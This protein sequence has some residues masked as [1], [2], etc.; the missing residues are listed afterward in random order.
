MPSTS[1]A[2]RSILPPLVLLATVLL[3]LFG[4][5]PGAGRWVRVLTDSAHAPASAVIAA[6]FFSWR[7]AAATPR[8]LMHH[9]IVSLALTVTLGVLIEIMQYFIG[10]DAELDDVIMDALGALA[11]TSIC[12]LA[13]A[14]RGPKQTQ[15]WLSSAALTIALLTTFVVAWPVLVMAKAYVDRDARFPVLMDADAFTGTYFLTPYWIEVSRAPLPAPFRTGQI[16]H[17]SYRVRL[18]SDSHWGLALSE[19]PPDWRKFTMLTIDIVNPTASHLALAVRIFSDPH[20]LVG[21]PGFIAYHATSQVGAFR[22]RIPLSQLN[23][24]TGKQH[25]DLSQLR[26]MV[27]H[28]TSENRAREF[29]LVK[30]RV[31]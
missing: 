21:R 28:G 20:G 17:H 29:Y 9:W 11:G 25:V 7:R 19:L 22:W 12:V 27:I 5:L 13:T 24:A 10:R 18:N 14:R 26:G 31:E 3:I 6:C 23:Q 16:S 2:I 30:V 15:P 4:Q 8:S 1:P